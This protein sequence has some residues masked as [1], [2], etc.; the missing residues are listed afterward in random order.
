MGRQG[1]ANKWSDS[2]PWRLVKGCKR[3]SKAFLFPFIDLKRRIN[4]TGEGIQ[5]EFSVASS[6]RILFDSFSIRTHTAK[7]LVRALF[8]APHTLRSPRPHTGET[9]EKNRLQH[10]LITRSMF[11][12]FEK[13]FSSSQHLL[14]VVARREN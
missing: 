14:F 11:R 2:Q 5:S 12:L 6:S 13:Q 3:T 1:K 9:R 7:D 8:P 4:S 10:K